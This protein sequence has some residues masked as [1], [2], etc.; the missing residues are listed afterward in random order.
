MRLSALVA[1]IML[2]ASCSSGE[3]QQSADST[4]PPNAIRVGSFDFNESKLLA[5]IYTRAMQDSGF[6]AYRLPDSASREIMQPALRQGVVDLLPEYLGTGLDFVTF[7]KTAV[8]T[9]P[10]VAH[11]L[12][13]EALADEGVSALDYAPAEDV[14]E[15]AVLA[16]TADE[17]NLKQISDLSRVDEQLVFGGPAECIAR[18]TCLAG[19]EEV[20]G[21]RFKEFV[22]LDPGGPLTLSALRG[23]EI[24]IGILFST[25]PALSDPDL[26]A[27]K[28]DHGLQPPENV[29]P[30]MTSSVLDE[31][32]GLEKIIDDVSAK[33]STADLRRLNG[34]VD[35]GSLSV[36]EAAQQWLDLEEIS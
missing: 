19:L 1:T 14:N 22:P 32:E 6:T 34:L 31:K 4:I 16:S 3:G 30:I 7:G 24:D 20:Y 9:D 5:E 11:D 15:V 36:A 2:A 29:V 28:D 33:L 23:G 12:M 8:P 27:L 26:V 17:L 35:D 10:A 21:L 25:S 18:D 13:N